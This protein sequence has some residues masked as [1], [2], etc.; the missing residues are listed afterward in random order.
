MPKRQFILVAGVDWGDFVID[1]GKICE[2][3]MRILSNMHAGHELVFTIFDFRTGL[4]K[5]YEVTGSGQAKAPLVRK[6][7]KP[8]KPGEYSRPDDWVHYEV[9]F[10]GKAKGKMSITDVYAE[11]QRI[12]KENPGELFEMSWF[13]L[14]DGVSTIEQPLFI[15]TSQGNK[16][17]KKGEKIRS[18]LD[19]D[20]KL[21]ID[22]V[23][24]NMSAEQKTFFRAAF[25][26]EGY[27]WLWNQW[28]YTRLFEYA[29]LRLVLSRYVDTK[30]SAFR[31]E[32]L[33]DF[34][35]LP[36]GSFDLHYRT[37]FE[38]I[39]RTH[40]YDYPGRLF[41]QAPYKT[42]RKVLYEDIE[43]S[44]PFLFSKA[45]GVPVY[46]ISAFSS[47]VPD[48]D[49][50]LSLFSVKGFSAEYH[51]AFARHLGIPVDPEGRNY[52]FF[53]DKIVPPPDTSFEELK[54]IYDDA[55]PPAPVQPP[56]VP[57][58]QFPLTLPGGRI[59]REGLQHILVAG[60]DFTFSGIDFLA[61]C[62][63][64]VT[65]LAGQYIKSGETAQFHIFDFTGGTIIHI[66]SR[67]L[68]RPVTETAGQALSKSDFKTETDLFGQKEFVFDGRKQA[69][70][71]LSVYSMIIETGAH[72]PGSLKELSFFCHTD[73]QGPLTLNYTDEFFF[74]S[75]DE[76]LK[77]PTIDPDRIL[78]RELRRAGEKK[79]FD[80]SVKWDFSN[81]LLSSRREAESF[82]SAWHRAPDIRFWFYQAS[83]S[84]A[85]LIKAV[86]DGERKMKPGRGQ[87]AGFIS[88]EQAL[89]GPPV[90][91]P[92]PVPGSLA[93]FKDNE[94]F[95]IVIELRHP[96]KRL[97]HLM[98]RITG[99][100]QSP[101]KMKER[102]GHLVYV[103]GKIM[104]ASYMAHLAK[105]SG[106]T[107]HAGIPGLVTDFVVSRQEPFKQADVA[108]FR[109]YY[110]FFNTYFR[111]EADEI[112]GYYAAYT[113]ERIWDDENFPGEEYREE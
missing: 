62:R 106:K 11:V 42:F 25:S 111:I 32:D 94:V 107:V 45:S 21:D 38:D 47:S 41:T 76:D 87:S 52:L 33:I 39:Y 61:S 69:M 81:F 108:A 29:P 79:F 57:V 95:N 54:K 31:D 102:L 103:L 82:R 35:D 68:D 98:K 71:M 101:V 17:N 44:Y 7:F 109:K 34:S 37:L 97:R 73:E 19:L 28:N 24:P 43:D 23:P 66:D 2:N 77:S 65:L 88:Q 83:E 80:P 56:P 63:D 16:L 74:I 96:D 104:R 40:F 59:R 90:E 6:K 64:R 86:V 53:S 4:V 8:V 55:H 75:L 49:G 51:A 92:F 112:K 93:G 105:A 18:P 99:K 10:T 70:T 48:A 113:P 50:P 67:A 46:G 30:G 1:F 9:L 20:P 72:A 100:D 91:N 27:I 36:A 12:G 13:Y 22:F 78:E 26:E 3:R 89:P 5:S 60:F 15:F 14:T 110:A 84:V 58:P 85:M